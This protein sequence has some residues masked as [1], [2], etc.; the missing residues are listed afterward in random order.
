MSLLSN[1]FPGLSAL[2]TDQF[3]LMELLYREWNAMINIISRKDIDQLST[4]HILH[5]LAIAKVITFKPGTCVM[6]AGTGGGF[7]GIPLAVMFPD[8]QFTLVDSIGKKI[9]V[10]E[11]IATELQLS[12]VKTMNVRFE[13]VTGQFDFITGRAVSKLPPFVAMLKKCIRRKGINDIPNGILYLTG[14]EFE[15]D[16]SAIKA[17]ATVW[18]LA[19]F[20]TESYFST[21]KLVHLHNFS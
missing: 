16:L 10:I 19:S 21:K 1:Y 3:A 7:P 17:S 14:G 12:N 5:S 2:Q 11:T 8:V 18:D 15:N 6:D 4:H 9:R 13:T 20:F